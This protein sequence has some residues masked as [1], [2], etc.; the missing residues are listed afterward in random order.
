M[1]KLFIHSLYDIRADVTGSHKEVQC[2][3]TPNRHNHEFYVRNVQELSFYFTGSTPPPWQRP[4]KP[5]KGKRSPCNTPQRHQVEVDL[6]FYPRTTSA[7]EGDGWSTSRTGRFTPEKKTR[8]QLCRRLGR[9]RGRIR[10]RKTRCHRDSKPGR[11]G[12]SESLY[13]LL[14][15][16]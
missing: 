9:S 3:T 16:T 13:Q 1:K 15:P 14:S 2:M 8:F 12:C 6:S 10:V 4:T 7:L 5:V 11:A